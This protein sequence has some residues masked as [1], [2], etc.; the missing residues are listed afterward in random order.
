MSRTLCI[1]H[2]PHY[3]IIFSYDMPFEDN[4]VQRTR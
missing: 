2:F 1:G 3:I 4:I